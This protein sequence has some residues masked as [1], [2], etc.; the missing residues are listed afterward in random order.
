[1]RVLIVD[2]SSSHRT[3]LRRFLEELGNDV[4]EASTGH[5]AISLYQEVRPDWV[6]LDR[7]MPDMGGMSTLEHLRSV[8]PHVKVV[9]I[10]SSNTVSELLEAREAGAQAFLLKP[11]KREKVENTLRKLK[12]LGE[13]K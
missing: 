3:R 10:S 11:L 6:A 5:D 2:D 12:L 4:T 9:M 1:M 13:G 7:V 8:D